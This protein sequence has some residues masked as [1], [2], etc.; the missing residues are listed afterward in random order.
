M[1]R[2][3]KIGLFVLI[4]GAG[5]IYY[6]VQTADSLDAPSTYQVQAYIKDASGLR[7]GTQVWVAGVDVGRIR[8]IDLEQGQARL[9]MELSS[10]VPVYRDAVI[11]KQTQS[12]LGNAIVALDPGTPQ[13]VPIPHGGVIQNVVSSSGMEQAFGSIDELAKEMRSFMEKLNSLMDEKGGYE[14]I[15]DI[16][17]ISRDTVANTS[18]MVEVNLALLQESLEN[19]AVV[20]ERL[21]GN[22]VS[23]LQDLS[24]ILRHTAG[25]T[26]RVDRLLAQ[27]D[28]RIADT[29]VSLQASIENLN[30]S[31]ENIKNVTSK[32]ERG[33]G[34]LGKLVNEDDLYVKIDKVVTGVDEFIDSALGMDVQV[35]FRSEYM[36]IDQGTKNHADVRLAYADKG[37]YYSVGLV[38]SMAGM[39]DSGSDDD[40]DDDLKISAQLARE[41]GPLTLRGGVIENSVGLGLEFSPIEKLNLASEVFSFS[42]DGGPYLRGYGTFYPIYDPR[43][44]NPLNWLYLAGGVDNALTSDRDYFLGLGLRFTDN[45]LKGIL[46]YAP[47]P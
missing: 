39:S 31:L 33:E 18:R 44:N 40:D 6:V 14:A 43:S 10:I 11:R 26:E 42:Q 12:M 13:S 15:G 46:P 21:E 29:M 30:E 24:S 37:K 7:P 3:V 36:T 9:M 4:T 32:I 23:D 45:D 27:Q 17:T 38:S 8:E 5:S 16:L 20:T 41:Y 47:S 35:G 25:I 22:S 19:I 1:N 28:G 34:N 2:L